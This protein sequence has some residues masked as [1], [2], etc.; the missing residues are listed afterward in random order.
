MEKQ[1][2]Q[3]L[4]EFDKIPIVEQTINEWCKLMEDNYRFSKIK[5]YVFKKR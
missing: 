5:G 1:I 4:R 2:I 3:P